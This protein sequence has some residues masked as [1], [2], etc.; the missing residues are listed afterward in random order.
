MSFPSKMDQFWI[1]VE[2]RKYLDTVG[3]RDSLLQTWYSEDHQQAEEVA[4][5]AVAAAA[6]QKHAMKHVAYG[7]NGIVKCS[8][9]LSTWVLRVRLN[10]RCME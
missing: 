1:G 4:V 2:T 7:S 3:E 9:L 5:K 10:I 8:K 6:T